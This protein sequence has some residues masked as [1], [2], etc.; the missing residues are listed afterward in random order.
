[1]DLT[2]T[3]QRLKAYAQQWLGQA[4][5]GWQRI[6][7]VPSINA[8]LRESM[9]DL[10]MY[11]IRHGVTDALLNQHGLVHYILPAPEHVFEAFKHFDPQNTVA[12]ILGQDPYPDPA[13]A[14][15]LSFSTRPGRPVPGSL[16]NVYTAMRQCGVITTIPT[17]ADLLPIAQQGVLWLNR[18]L[19][20]SPVIE[21]GRVIRPGGSKDT[22]CMH[23]FWVRF[24]DEL[25]R[26]LMTE[27]LPKQLN[28]LHHYACLMLWGKV[29]QG[30]LK[31]GTIKETRTPAV[32]VEI[33]TSGHPSDVNTVN[34]DPGNPEA[35]IHVNHFRLANEGLARAHAGWAIEW[36]PHQPYVPTVTGTKKINH[37]SQFLLKLRDGD[38]TTEDW[39]R[40]RGLSQCYNDR[41]HEPHNVELLAFIMAGRTVTPPDAK[42]SAKP[43]AKPG[44][45]L[46]VLVPA[47]GYIVLGVD[48]G[49]EK[50]GQ[51]N[52]RASY[53]M[54]RPP[55]YRG[56]PNALPGESVCGIVP[57][58]ELILNDQS[59][60]EETGVRV[61]P[62]N[63]RGEMLAM[64]YAL[65]ALV[66]CRVRAPMHI[67]LDSEYVMHF[68]Q[69]RMW[70]YLLKNGDRWISLIK[71]NKDLILIIY[72]LIA[73]LVHIRL[74]VV[75]SSDQDGGNIREVWDRFFQ[76][77]AHEYY[78]NPRPMDLDWPELTLI[79]QNSHLKAPRN[80][81]E[82]EPFVINGGADALCNKALA[83]SV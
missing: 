53:G 17:T 52:A 78:A 35:F 21:G 56:L 72:R 3:G 44:A 15:G 41:T 48:G 25:V 13:N 57:L 50:N 81:A 33:F 47:P 65:R 7:Q 60:L 69:E 19:T 32:T 79:H 43:G 61:A 77:Q 2:V 66:G 34:K 46:P 36:D 83:D 49:C 22:D 5:P 16:Y 58:S 12:I 64:I 39:V 1:M 11:L 71:A 20:R 29:S 31:A 24:T 75:L 14:M 70:K 74:G 18:Y 6:M 9:K 63:N 76:P 67:I 62:T 55:T 30:I 68:V 54:F 45:K 28:H 42:P 73:Q 38:F 4:R 82:A 40:K 51:R 10:D 59:E 8:A 37:M 26:Y 27:F 23:T 80:T